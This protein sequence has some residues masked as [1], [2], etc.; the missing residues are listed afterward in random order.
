MDDGK[1]DW[2]VIEQRIYDEALVAIE[3][4]A[5]ASPSI[6]LA[7]FV[8]W[9]DPYKGWYEFVADTVERNASG[10][11]ARNAGLPA[12]VDKHAEWADGWKTAQSTARQLVP[13][14]YD[15]DYSEY[16]FELSE[17]E[18]HAFEIDVSGF[19]ESGAYTRLNFGG[20]D[21]WLEGHMRFV[22]AKALTR[23]VDDQAFS[24]VAL[25]R[26]FRVGYAF[27]DESHVT[28]TNLVFDWAGG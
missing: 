19:V 20:Q 25:G 6:R 7:M 23:L 5:N 1:P 17:D 9:A 14:T 8:L 10:A 4:I 2:K 18:L 27:N 26:E 21:G 3:V 16:F 12:L 22:F 24:R 28:V 13:L 15:P 11:R